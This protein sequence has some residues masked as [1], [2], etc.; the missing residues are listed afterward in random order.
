MK[1]IIFIA[2]VMFAS[3]TTKAQLTHTKWSG[4]LQLDNAVNVVFDFKA[5]TL[6]V[7]VVEDN[8]TLESMIYT[9]Q[10]SILT[11]KKIQGQSDCND[12][13]GKY[14][15][16]MQGD[17][18]MLSTIEDACGNRAGVLDKTKWMKKE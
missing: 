16:S 10:D 2:L 9:V 13:L 18:L 11:I 5:D 15:I 7:V 1:K 4:T 12:E 14:K 6:D 17:E 8:S 3:A